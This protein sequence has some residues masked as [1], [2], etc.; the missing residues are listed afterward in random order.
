MDVNTTVEAPKKVRTLRKK[1][2][3]PDLPIAWQRRDE[4]NG[5]G[6]CADQSDAH[7]VGKDT[8]MAKD[9][10]ENGGMRRMKPRTQSSPSVL[11]GEM[12]ECTDRWRRVSVDEVDVYVP[13]NAQVEAI[14]TTNRRITF[15]EVESGDEAIAPS[16]GGE[17]AGDVAGEGKK[18]GE[19]GTTSG[20][21]IDS[22]RVDATLLA[23][24]SQRTRYSRIS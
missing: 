17:T 24:E 8:E 20:S 23:E 14:S 19:G 16:A 4:P 21:D 11:E 9:Q 5:V 12:P 7:N 13:W 10:S 2:K 1:L 15:G 6:N 3:P 18:N 22:T